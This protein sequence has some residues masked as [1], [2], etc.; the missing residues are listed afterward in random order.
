ML[1]LRTRADLDSIRVRLGTNGCGIEALRTFE[2]YTSG[3]YTSGS[4]TSGPES[5]HGLFICHLAFGTHLITCSVLSSFWNSSF[6]LIRIR[7][8]SIL[9]NYA[10]LAKAQSRS[11]K[12]SQVCDLT[13]SLELG[14]ES[15][16]HR[17]Q[18]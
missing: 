3:S 12:S 4:Y 17:V 10:C 9:A 6:R 11:V 16:Q 14:L 7:Y 2:V 1:I 13:G 18:N 5:I 8:S 15:K